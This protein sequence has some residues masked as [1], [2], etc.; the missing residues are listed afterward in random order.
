MKKILLFISIIL[1]LASCNDSPVIDYKHKLNIEKVRNVRLI[2][3]NVSLRERLAICEYTVDTTLSNFRA[4]H[5]LYEMNYQSLER[6]DT[7][8]GGLK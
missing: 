6:S 3:E 4:H 5:L 8:W 1:I 2:R 7:T